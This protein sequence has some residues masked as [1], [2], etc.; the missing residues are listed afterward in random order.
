MDETQGSWTI[1][2]EDRKIPTYPA[3]LDDPRTLALAIADAAWAKNAYGTRILDVGK[4]VSY[5]DVFVILTGRSDR[6]VMAVADAIQEAM[7]AKGVAPIGVEGRQAGTWILLDFG[8]VVVHVFEKTTRDY[9]DLEKLWSDAVAVPVTEPAWVQ[10]F[11]RVE[12]G[13]D[14]S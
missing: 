12:T 4:L 11:A 14:A 8:S 9:Y 5:T 1:S 7:K 13:Y 6:H 2:K 10:E 3:P